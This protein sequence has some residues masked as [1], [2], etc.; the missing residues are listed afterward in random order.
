ML[1]SFELNGVLYDLDVLHPHSARQRGNEP[2]VF[3]P[4][5]VLNQLGGGQGV[6]IGLTSMLDPGNT[7]GLSRA[8]TT[9]SSMVSAEMIM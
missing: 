7:P 1:Y 2:A 4:E 3:V 8:T 5:E 9:A 6:L